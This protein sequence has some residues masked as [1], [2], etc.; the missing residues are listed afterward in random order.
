MLLSYTSA[1]DVIVTQSSRHEV[2]ME[3]T[4]KRQRDLLRSQAPGGVEAITLDRRATSAWQT[5]GGDLAGQG[6]RGGSADRRPEPATQL[7]RV[8][9][10]RAS[11]EPGHSDD[12]PGPKRGQPPRPR[13]P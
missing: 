11:V 13:W 6:Y 10:S 9:N 7:R 4:P 2:V 12:D 8:A 3:C 1:A 5:C